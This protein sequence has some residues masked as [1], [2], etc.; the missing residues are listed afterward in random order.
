MVK[1]LGERP[2][3]GS[4]PDSLLALHAAGYREVRARLGEGVILDAGCGLG[5]ETV[6][7][8]GRGRTVVGFDYDAAT[9]A[10]AGSAFA[11]E[12]LKIACCDA[13][14]TCFRDAS[15]DFV[16]SS[17]L[18]EHFRRPE[19]HVAEMARLLRRDGSAMILTPNRTADFENPYHLHLFDRGELAETLGAFFAEVWVVGLDGSEAVKADFA[20]RRRRAE[21][22]LRLD[23][24]KLRKRIPHRW[25]TT[26]YSA[27]LPVLYRLMARNDSGGA[28]GI[29]SDDFRVTTDVDD[30]TL[31][32]L[33][34]CRSP[35]S[36][37]GDLKAQTLN[38][39]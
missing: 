32:L 7:L 29:T 12:G 5:F 18:I 30:T 35:R 33:A 20:A 13:L 21:K 22:I 34:V 17:H 2:V 38:V 26:I 31:V 23:F 25:Y 1:L 6:S 15:F 19:L 11:G 39:K 4:T 28:T 8:G 24:L 16:C 27:A 10:R 36:N 37:S 3:E 14:A 9:A